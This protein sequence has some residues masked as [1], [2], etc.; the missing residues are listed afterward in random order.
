[1]TAEL[2]IASLV[3]HAAPKRIDQVAEVVAAMSGAFI[4]ATSGK[5]K[6]VVT[7]EA[8]TAEAMTQSVSLIQRIDGVLSAALVYQCTDSLD[9]MN[10][11]V[12]D[13]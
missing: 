9:V 10:E 2:H 6:L 3:V 8:D 12:S 7:L 4:H 1:M 5:G 13:A 11:E